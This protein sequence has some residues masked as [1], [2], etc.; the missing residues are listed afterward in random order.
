M[1]RPDHLRMHDMLEAIRDIR[2]CTASGRESFMADRMAQH[3]VMYCLTV[4]GECVSRMT[5][6]TV[7]ELTSLSGHRAIALRNVIVHKYWR[8][9]LV[10]L[11]DTITDV[12][13]ALEDDLRRASSSMGHTPEFDL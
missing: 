2:L 9:D 7:S 13:P 10:S 4:I 11:W 8:V 5:E 1:S 3:A 12:L 6:T